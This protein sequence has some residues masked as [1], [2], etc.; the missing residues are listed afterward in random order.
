MNSLLSDEFYQVNLEDS[1]ERY[2]D[3]VYRISM[4]ITKNQ[5]DAQDVF[6]ETFLR[7]VKYKETIQSEEHLKAWLIRVA[8]NCGKTLASDIWNNRTQGMDEGITGDLTYEQKEQGTLLKYIRRLPKKYALPL[9]LFYY[10]E[11]SIQEIADI[12]NKNIN[13]VKSYLRRGKEKLRKY[14]AEDGVSI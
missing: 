3:M 13:T 1:V 6:Q 9:Y 12:M 8:S 11:Y 4:T 2:A 10:E 5:Q 7:L 14:L